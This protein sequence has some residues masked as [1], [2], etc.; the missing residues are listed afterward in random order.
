MCWTIGACFFGLRNS[1]FFMYSVYMKNLFIIAVI[2]MFAFCGCR[3]KDERELV[4]KVPQMQT[5]RDVAK[6]R[7]SLLLLKGLDLKDAKFDLASQTV[8]V[9]YDSMVVANKNIEIVIAEAG[10]D[11]NGISA[12][13]K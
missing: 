13:K 2:S 12:I 1:V 11:A 3:I 7:K 5:E 10:Y 8:T 4:V 6:V 9:K